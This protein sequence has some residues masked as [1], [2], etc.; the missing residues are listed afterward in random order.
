VIVTEPY[1][2][3]HALITSAR[4]VATMRG[5]DPDR[6]EATTR[7]LIADPSAPGP[8]VDDSGFESREDRDRDALGGW[9]A[10][11]DRA[12]TEYERSRGL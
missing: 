7:A 8:D 1:D 10:G 2:W 5:E 4:N 3:Q 12:L 6:A 9:G 11:E